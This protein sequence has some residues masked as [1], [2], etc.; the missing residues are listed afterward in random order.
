MKKPSSTS[1]EDRKPA[2]TTI[3]VSKPLLQRLNILRTKAAVLQGMPMSQEKLLA[4]MADLAEKE[5]DRRV[6][7]KA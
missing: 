4:W 7:I 1:P 5:L 3:A 6:E 2:R